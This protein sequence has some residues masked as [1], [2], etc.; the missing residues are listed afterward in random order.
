MEKFL[1][2]GSESDDDWDWDDEHYAEY[3]RNQSDDYVDHLDD[4]DYC[5]GD[6]DFE[7]DYGCDDDFEEWYPDN[8]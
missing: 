7:P 6:D 8:N 4:V 3:K 2:K 5:D 1:P